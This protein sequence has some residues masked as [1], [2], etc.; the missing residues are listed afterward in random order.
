MPRF[1]KP[2]PIDYWRDALNQ[3]ARRIGT[4]DFSVV[5]RF[6]STR[7][8]IPFYVGRSDNPLGRESAHWYDLIKFRKNRWLHRRVSFVDFA[9]F[10]G[11]RRHRFAFE[12]ECRSYH[13]DENSLVNLN[14]PAGPAK[15]LCPVC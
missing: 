12:Q 10:R 7:T 1:T 13:Y 11:R 14:H 8:G 5:Y 6:Y 2:I 9:I 15:W 3:V 4:R